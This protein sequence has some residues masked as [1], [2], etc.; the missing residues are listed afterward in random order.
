MS[1]LNRNTRG[2]RQ[3]STERRRW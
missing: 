3:Y 1:N 2:S